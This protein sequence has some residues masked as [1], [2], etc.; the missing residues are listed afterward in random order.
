M[1]SFRV[2]ATGAKLL[3][4]V[5]KISLGRIGCFATFFLKGGRINIKLIQKSVKLRVFPNKTLLFIRYHFPTRCVLF[6]VVENS[7]VENWLN[8]VERIDRSSK[9]SNN[10]IHLAGD[11]MLAHDRNMNCE[12]RHTDVVFTLHRKNKLRGDDSTSSNG[13]RTAQSYQHTRSN[14]GDTSSKC[15]ELSLDKWCLDM[16]SMVMVSG[17]KSV[18]NHLCDVSFRP[19]KSNIPKS[20]RKKFF[21]RKISRRGECHY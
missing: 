8:D 13:R 9:R 5:Y 2:I 7:S 15:L 3:V 10:N 6:F 17:A 20:S 4:S 11:A 19:M 16:K 1:L 14:N 12:S 18:T 21:F